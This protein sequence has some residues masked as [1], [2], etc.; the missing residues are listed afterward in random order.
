MNW[1]QPAFSA[2]RPGSAGLHQFDNIVVD[3]STAAIPEPSSFAM[4]GAG[5]LMALG[6]AW[7]KRTRAAA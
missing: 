3:F 2:R 5:M 7:R 4:V 1:Q 6:Y